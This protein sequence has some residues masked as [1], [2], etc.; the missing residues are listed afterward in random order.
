MDANGSSPLGPSDHRD[1]ADKRSL[2]TPGLSQDSR[3][4]FFRIAP[5]RQPLPVKRPRWL[6]LLGGLT[7]RCLKR[8]FIDS[9]PGRLMQG[10]FELV[11]LGVAFLALQVWWLSSVLLKRQR[12]GGIGNQRS[13]LQRLFDRS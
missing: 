10:A 5:I 7:H 2:S 3:E 9:K 1:L 8:W 11:V 13:T 4:L 12:A 6:D